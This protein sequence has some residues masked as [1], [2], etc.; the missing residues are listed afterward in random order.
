MSDKIIKNPY[1][2]DKSSLTHS[3]YVPEWIRLGKEPIIYEGN[4]SDA[5]FLNTKKRSPMKPSNVAS[6]QE[7]A[8]TQS[9][10]IKKAPVVENHIPHQT[11]ISVGQNE[12]WFDPRSDPDASAD[13]MYD[14]IP[15]PPSSLLDDSGISDEQ[16]LQPGEY[17]ILIKGVI[18]VKTFILKEAEAMIEKI[19]FDQLP[20]FSKVSI[21]DIAL[22]MRLPLK[23]GVLAVLE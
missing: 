19:L 2:K 16:S 5:M 18:V 14:E 4:S 21:D 13:I 11:K 10:K 3:K 17:G 1:R 6:N 9:P 23:V 7:Q 20:Q 8:V 15:D 12:N 22:H